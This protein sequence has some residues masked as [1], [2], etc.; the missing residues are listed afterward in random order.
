MHTQAVEDYLKA[1]YKLEQR[2]STVTTTL[3]AEFLEITPASA[4][5]MLK[6]LRGMNLV[7]YAP[8]KGVSLTNAG[9]KTALEMIRHHRL[10]E[11]YL[12]EALG[13][14]WDK[15]HEEAEKWEH[16]L[17]EDIEDRI[18]AILGHPTAD[19]HGAPIPN[20]EG[21][22]AVPT[23]HRLADL[24][25]GQSGVIAEVSDHDP[26]LLRYLGDLTLYPETEFS[27]IDVAPFNGPVPIQIGN[28][29]HVLGREVAGHVLVT[30]TKDS[31][32]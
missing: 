1:I 11:L 23:D 5:A 13:V 7:V 29:Q 22:V 12:A 9:Q 24:E 8:Y 28:T 27:V 17:S 32:S 2:G 3:L 14:P 21:A 31:N 10:L 30:I 4:T 6:K 20:R 19:P 18:D 16:V 26:A 25:V 15:V